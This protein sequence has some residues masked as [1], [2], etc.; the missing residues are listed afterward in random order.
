MLSFAAELPAA[1]WSWH[2]S[3]E[4]EYHI[5]IPAEWTI[6]D[7]A[8]VR[9]STGLRP[10]FSFTPKSRA[11]SLFIAYEESGEPDSSAAERQFAMVRKSCGS[12]ERH[13]AALADNSVFEYIRSTAA[14]QGAVSYA[15]HG[16][17]FKYLERYCVTFVSPAGFPAGADWENALK[18]LASLDPDSM[19]LDGWQE[20]Y[21]MKSEGAAGGGD[22]GK[23]LEALKQATHGHP[24]GRLVDFDEI[25]LFSCLNIP[26]NRY[27]FNQDR[28]A[29][30]RIVSLEDYRLL[31]GKLAGKYYGKNSIFFDVC[32][33]EMRQEKPCDPARRRNF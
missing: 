11:F 33:E 12:T 9:V 18:A 5:N 24:D 19:T 26:G 27:L 7:P 28:T 10:L 25:V 31:G 6:S 22:P 8:S 1:D 4:A 32:P 17:L 23:Q 30:C 15:V 29:Q 13:R 16:V 21:K 3:V 2:R 14:A 20:E